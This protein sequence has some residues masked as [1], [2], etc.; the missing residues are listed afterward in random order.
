MDLVDAPDSH[1]T[2]VGVNDSTMCCQGQRIKL[3]PLGL[4]S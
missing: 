3:S 1:S 4:R 2:D